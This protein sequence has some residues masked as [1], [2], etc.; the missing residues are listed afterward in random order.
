MAGCGVG[1]TA[2]PL[3]L[4]RR[5]FV[6]TAVL[7]LLAPAGALASKKGGLR[8]IADCADDGEIHGHYTQ[9]D[10]RYALGHLPSDLDEYTNCRDAI[11]AASRAGAGGGPS[12][13]G[14][15]GGGGASG[16]APP[17]G[18][19]P[20]PAPSSAPRPPAAVSAPKSAA[21]VSVGGGPPVTPG[22]PGITTTSFT[23][24]LPGPLLVAVL[25]LVLGGLAALSPAIRSRVLSRSQG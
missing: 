24:A 21:P 19:A 23:H 11:R 17:A 2:S 18:T 7:C 6:L 8:L 22:G 25:L 9:S 3:S 12:S 4:M 16:S 20:A 10:Y 15:S 5:V 13:S 14:G 1:G